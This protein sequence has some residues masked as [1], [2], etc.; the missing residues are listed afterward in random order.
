MATNS[1]PSA[2]ATT[3]ATTMKPMKTPRAVAGAK[4]GSAE[5]KPACVIDTMVARTVIAI[6]PKNCWTVFMRAV[7][8]A[9]SG[10]ST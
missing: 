5:V 1:K 4:S 8:S 3:T 10:P 7:P 2:A 6:A 9:V